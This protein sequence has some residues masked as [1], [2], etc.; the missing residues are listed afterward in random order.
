MLTVLCCSSLT[1]FSSIDDGEACVHRAQ[2]ILEKISS[3]NSTVESAWV[4]NCTRSKL[5]TSSR[6]WHR[7]RK[8]T[9]WYVPHNSPRNSRINLKSDFRQL[10]EALRIEVERITDIKVVRY[11]LPHSV[12]CTDRPR[13]LSERVH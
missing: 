6:A 7:P 11:S 13:P 12:L 9:A 10:D 3:L 5:T 8:G 4:I 1:H 2:E